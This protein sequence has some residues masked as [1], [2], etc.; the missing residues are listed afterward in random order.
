MPFEIF[1]SFD[2]DI[3]H[4]LMSSA[5]VVSWLFFIWGDISKATFKM[6]FLSKET[7]EASSVLIIIFSKFSKRFYAIYDLVLTSFISY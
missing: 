1:L 2:K 7:E 5:F 3:S 4:V 6:F